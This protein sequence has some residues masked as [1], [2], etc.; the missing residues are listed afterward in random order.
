M[1][2]F[3]EAAAAAEAPTVETLAVSLE[4]STTTRQ[5]WLRTAAY[6]KHRMD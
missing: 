6:C 3:V 1:D 5:E 4:S 2:A